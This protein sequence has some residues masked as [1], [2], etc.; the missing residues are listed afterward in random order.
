M[1]TVDS[2]SPQRR[3]AAD[4]LRSLRERRAVHQFLKFCAVGAASTV[5]DF[6]VFALLD[7]VVHLPE[8]FENVIA[9]DGLERRR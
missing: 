8:H 7:R 9:L 2:E 4:A 3:G 1:T 6:G 5:I